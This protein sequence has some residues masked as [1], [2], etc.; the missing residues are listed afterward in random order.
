MGFGKTNL[1]MFCTNQLP[2]IRKGLMVKLRHT[3]S[4]KQRLEQVRQIAGLSVA[5]DEAFE[6]DVE[7]LLSERFNGE[8]VRQLRGDRR[9]VEG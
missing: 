7:I 5:A 1:R 6:R 9:T 3:A 2:A 8:A 4:M